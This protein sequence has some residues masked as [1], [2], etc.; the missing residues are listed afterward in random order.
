MC[1]VFGGGLSI[2]N[3]GQVQGIDEFQFTSDVEVVLLRQYVSR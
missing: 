2:L 1:S 3:K